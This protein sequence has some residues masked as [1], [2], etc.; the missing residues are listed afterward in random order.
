MDN[1]TVAILAKTNELLERYGIHP[2]DVVVTTHYDV[3]QGTTTLFFETPPGDADAED[4][5]L[6]LL[7]S[8]GLSDKRLKLV[9]D[10]REIYDKLQGAL[11]CAPKAR[12]GR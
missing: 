4:R 12:P 2:C 1:N 8:L 6:R 7:S 9:G 11:R 10:D 3:Q 5:F